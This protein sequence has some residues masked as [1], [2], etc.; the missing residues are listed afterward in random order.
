MI[1]VFVLVGISAIVN[2]MSACLT[3]GSYQSIFS[4][5]N[6]LQI[7]LLI[8][9]TGVYFPTKVSELIHSMRPALLTFY[10][11]DCDDLS[12]NTSDFE[13]CGYAQSN[14]A[15]D[16]IGLQLGST[17]INVHLITAIFIL[18]LIFHLMLLPCYLC[19]VKKEKDGNFARLI[20]SCVSLLSFTV[21][22]RFILEAFLLICIASFSEIERFDTGNS[23]KT[24]SLIIALVFSFLIAIFF[25]ISFVHW[26]IY[27]KEEELGGRMKDLYS[28]LKPFRWSRTYNLIFMARRIVF[29]L[30]LVLLKN[31]DE[32]LRISLI[33]G[34]QAAYCLYLVV[35]RPFQQTKDTVLE[36]INEFGYLIIC[37]AFIYF[38]KQSKWS[39]TIEWVY[40]CVILA[41]LAI[42]LFF[43]IG[44]FYI[45]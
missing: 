44:K 33:T 30:L 34:L 19:I 4:S 1:I 35:L 6:F 37:A 17:I 10:F 45:F 43:S 42:F 22:I 2:L 32:I 13:E 23:T 15:L 29:V 25:V 14:A 11:L 9:L 5:F 8:P 31:E 24:R 3:K 28:G 12:I 16:F 38:H 18:I 40:W 26:I 27:G 41:V 21:Y 20:T 7:M 39:N 36:C